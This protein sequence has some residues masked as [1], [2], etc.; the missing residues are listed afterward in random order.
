MH[1]PPQSA[2]NP[3]A[4]RKNGQIFRDLPSKIRQGNVNWASG[5]AKNE[6]E[7]PPSQSYGGQA[8]KGKRGGMFYPPGAINPLGAR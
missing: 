2:V 8:R 1:S 5:V 3:S 6:E 7:D 4:T